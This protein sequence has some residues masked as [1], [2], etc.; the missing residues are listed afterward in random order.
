M[1]LLLVVL[2]TVPAGGWTPGISD[3]T[4]A[5]WLTVAAYALAAS[6]AF[7]AYRSCRSESYRLEQTHPHEAA[8]ERLLACF[9]L[10]ASTT[11]IALGINKQLDLQS[12]FTE[13]LRDA[14]REQGWYDNRRQYQLAF[15]VAIGC[16]GVL[17]VGAMAWVLRRV[18]DRVWIAVLG[19]GWLTSFVVIRAASFHHVET[20]LRS[21]THAGNAAFEL[22]GITMVAVG[23]GRALR[24]RHDAGQRPRDRSDRPAPVGSAN[25]P[26]SDGTP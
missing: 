19:L 1:V 25:A 2:E 24:S 3:A 12:L 18:L 15:V 23:A 4:W 7:L 10:L 13:V 26:R 22:A 20:F 11:L 17:G 14:S 16:G 21:M 8:N 5:G 9:W 6:L